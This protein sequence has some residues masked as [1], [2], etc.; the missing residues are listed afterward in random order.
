MTENNV[1]YFLNSD[2]PLSPEAFEFLLQYHEEDSL[3][4]Y[5]KTMDIKCDKDWLELTKDIMAFANTEGGY[6]IFGV[7]N[8]T[9]NIVGIDQELA[10]FLCDASEMMKK[11]NRFIEPPI[12]LL[13][14]KSH[15][16]KGKILAGVLVPASKNKTHIIAK[17]GVFEY[18]SGG[19]KTVLHK[20]TLYVRKSAGNHLVDSRDLDDIIGRRLGD[21][22]GTLLDNIARV[23]EAPAKSEVFIMSPDPSAKTNKRFI[24]DDAPDA[25]PVKGMAFSVTPDTPEEE[26]AAWSAIRKGDED[27]FPPRATIW[28]WYD[29]RMQLKLSDSQR[30]EVA[31]ICLLAEVPAFYWLRGLSSEDILNMLFDA[32]LNRPSIF[33]SRN[34]LATA[35]FLGEGAY[36]SV[37]NRL[38]KYKK[39]IAP[40]LLRFPPAGPRSSFFEDTIRNKRTREYHNNEIAFRAKLESE[41]NAITGSV[42]EE[43]LKH[44]P[45]DKRSSAM[46]IDCYLYAQDDK[47]K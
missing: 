43:N 29:K 30:L 7:E 21:F 24:I 35:A 33:K 14:S 41:L 42:G 5:K 40:S 23:V 22:K 3:I 46:A 26:I 9:Y 17:D 25:I 11:V 39:R 18:P 12:T 6:L 13:R 44:P 20:G 38:G 28:H 19:Q 32:I 37:L 15:T 47:Y 2:D 27:A 4:D 8:A 36:S 45:Y 1:K 10:E 16:H 34:I 31:K